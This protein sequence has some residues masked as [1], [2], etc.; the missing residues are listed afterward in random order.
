[1]ADTQSRKY[2]LTLN[3][4]LDKQLDHDAI[5]DKVTTASWK[6]I[7]AS[8]DSEFEQLWNQMVSDCEGLGAQEIIDWRL[9]DIENAKQ[10]RDSLSAQ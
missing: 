6:M 2:Q 7:Y 10:V 3:N 9:A 4:P 1:M 8:S 5:K